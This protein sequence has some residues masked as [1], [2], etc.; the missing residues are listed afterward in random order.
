MKTIHKYHLTENPTELILPH[1]STVVCVHE[2]NGTPTLWI[3]IN[4]N[5]GAPMEKTTFRIVGTGGLMKHGNDQYIGTCF[6]DE[7]VWHV[8]KIM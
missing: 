7:F 5:A 6:I 4:L 8:Y 1:G 3:E 2:Q